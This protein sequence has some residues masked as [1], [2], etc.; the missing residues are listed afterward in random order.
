MVSRVISFFLRRL[1]ATFEI[2]DFMSREVAG[3]VAG[4]LR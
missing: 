3:R 4:H 1:D 2:S